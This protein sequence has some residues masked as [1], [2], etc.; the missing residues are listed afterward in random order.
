MQQAYSAII[1]IRANNYVLF[2]VLELLQQP[3]PS[4]YPIPNGGIVP[5]PFNDSVSFE[6]VSFSYADSTLALEGISFAIQK[7]ERIGVVGSS[8]SGKSTMVNLLMGLINPSR[9]TVLVDSK[10]LVTS[11]YDHTAEWR[12][13]I[14]HVPQDIFLID[15][16][17][18]RNIAFGLDECQID[19]DRIYRVCNTACLNDFI[20]SLPQGLDTRVGERGARLS[21]GQRQR[22]GIARALYKNTEVFIFDEATSALDNETEFSVMQ[23]I[24][25]LSADTTII[26]VAHRLSTV[27]HCDR[28]LELSNARLQADGS[29]SDLL[30]DS[31]T[32]RAMAS[33]SGL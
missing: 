25:Q 12:K 13:N 11:T 27:K 14:S 32:F 16:S 31:A 24:Q 22:I 9:G 5:I 28:I 33:L 2:G 30:R 23:S 8:G 7:G 18:A 19:Y 10:P 6:N 17:I 21:G 20:S 3:L 1:Q 4:F 26:L 29:F 15:G